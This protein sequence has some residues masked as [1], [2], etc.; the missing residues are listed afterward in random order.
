MTEKSA[1]E[2]F[3]RAGLNC[4]QAILT[5]LREEFAISDEEIEAARKAGAGKAPG[6]VCG[7]YHAATQ[8]ISDP[9]FVS[10]LRA[11][12]EQEAGSHFC[13]RIRKERNIGC[14]SCVALTERCLREHLEDNAQTSD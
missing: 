1:E 11:A 3:K 5:V 10:H 13:K 7:A 14:G 8:L 6:G 2:Y 4:A 12:F 9:T